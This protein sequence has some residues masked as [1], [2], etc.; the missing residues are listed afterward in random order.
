MMQ[1]LLEDRFKLRIHRATKVLPVYE[2]RI[3]KAGVK[4]QPAKGGNCL[5]VD[6]DHP[7][8]PLPE[9]GQPMPAICGGFHERYMYSATMQRLSSELSFRADRDV[10]DKTGLAGTFDLDFGS[11]PDLV[12]PI[13]EEGFPGLRHPQD[14]VSA[15]YIDALSRL[16]LKLV[17]ANGPTTV[18]VIDHI[19]RP[20]EN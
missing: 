13:P 11:S 16:G 4:L 6:S 18:I 15:F 20:S 5:I 14:R 3:A 9:P 2:L 19:E 17:P 7:P 1:A 8:P 10:V 12:S